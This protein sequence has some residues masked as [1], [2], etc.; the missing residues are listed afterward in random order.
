MP[1]DGYFG[2]G[3]DTLAHIER[4]LSD[5]SSGLERPAAMIL[6]TVQGEGGLNVA[7]VKWLQ[8]LQA[9]CNQHG[10]VLIVDDI[11]A[12]C[13]RTGTFFSF[14]P[15]GIKP[16]VITLSKSLSGYGLPMAMVVIKR[17]MDVWKPGEHNGTFRGNNHAFV[18]ATAALEHYWSTPAFA[19]SVRAKGEHLRR[20]L[21][22]MVNTFA[23][24]LVDVRGRGMM[25]GVRCADPK[26]AASVTARA[27][28]Y[29]LIIERAGPD[30]EVIKCMMPLTTSVRELDE[31]LD[32]LERAIAEEFGGRTI[33]LPKAA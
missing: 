22:M 6:E 15:A 5:P 10:I 32:I 13:G 12:G 2:E 1:F 16:D 8:R 24:H 18:T 7:N 33:D 30:D 19:E 29:G 23:P 20:R 11:Q 3:V 31:G 26:R 14:E 25:I 21:Q 4:V 27:Y 28:R 17:S 9:L